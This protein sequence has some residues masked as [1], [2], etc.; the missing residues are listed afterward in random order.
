MLGRVQHRDI[1]LRAVA[2]ACKL[3]RRTDHADWNDFRMQVV[4]AVSEAFNNIVLHSYAGR[5]DGI[6]E[7]DIRTGRN[8]IS[9]S[10]AT[11]AT[12]STRTVPR[13]G[14]RSPAGIGPGHVH[15]QELMD[16]SYTPGAAQRAH[17]VEA[18]NDSHAAVLPEAPTGESVTV[19][20]STKEAGTARIDIEGELDTVTVPDLRKEIDKLV[21]DAQARRGRPVDAAHAGQLG[22]R[23][24]GLA[25]QARARAA[26]RS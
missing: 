7:M 21:A 23:R 10:C 2:A 20:I 19:T 8:H 17:A 22:R 12:A 25:L 5:E 26:A 24:A 9:S 18:L 15:H 6:I 1:V 4:T 14:S 11:S 13:A 16:V 3:V